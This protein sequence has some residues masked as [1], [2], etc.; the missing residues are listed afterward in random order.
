MYPPP[1]QQYPSP[2]PFGAPHGMIAPPVPASATVLLICGVLK[3]FASALCIAGGL[4]A[5]GGAALF[6]GAS[7]GG[8]AWASLFGGLGTLFAGGIGVLLLCVGAGSITSGLLDT[9][10]GHYA[11]KGK[12]SGRIMGII[13]AVFGLLGAFGSMTAAFANPAVTHSTTAETT[14]AMATFSVGNLSG[15]LVLLALNAYLL[16]S[17]VRNGHAFKN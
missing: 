13:S 5:L 7:Q 15:G 11:R 16:V 14:D 6:A 9:V 8:D 1:Q 3:L 10:G 4:L 12:A 17:F 2:S